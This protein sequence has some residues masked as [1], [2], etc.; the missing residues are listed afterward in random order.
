MCCVSECTL[1]GLK[2]CVLLR[3]T[4]ESADFIHLA[5][6]LTPVT[7]SQFFTCHFSHQIQFASSKIGRTE[8]GLEHIE[9]KQQCERG[10]TTDLYFVEN[11]EKTSLFSS[12]S[13]G[14]RETPLWNTKFKPS[15]VCCQ[16]RVADITSHGTHHVYPRR[17]DLQAMDGGAICSVHAN[18]GAR[19]LLR[20]HCRT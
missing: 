5:P 4:K 12:V 6:Q 11:N 16:S 15:C 20:S 14:W 17:L 13:S 2:K 3:Q 8:A 18:Q 9:R 1:M 10:A 7:L 19:C